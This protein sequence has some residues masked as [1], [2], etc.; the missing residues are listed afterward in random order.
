[1]QSL[2]ERKS[3]SNFLSRASSQA[4]DSHK[5]FDKRLSF[6]SDHKWKTCH[7]LQRT[8]GMYFVIKYYWIGL[9]NNQKHKLRYMD[10]EARLSIAWSDIEGLKQRVTEDDEY[11]HDR[12]PK[13]LEY[14][15]KY[16]EATE[17]GKDFDDVELSSTTYE[18]YKKELNFMYNEIYMKNSDYRKNVNNQI[19]ELVDKIENIIYDFNDLIWISN[20]PVNELTTKFLMLRNKTVDMKNYFKLTKDLPSSQNSDEEKR[21]TMKRLATLVQKRFRGYQVRKKMTGLTDVSFTDISKLDTQ[22]KDNMH[23]IDDSN[24]FKKDDN[25]FL[26][27]YILDYHPDKNHEQI[28]YVGHH[29]YYLLDVPRTRDIYNIICELQTVKEFIKVSIDTNDQLPFKLLLLM[30]NM[31]IL[32]GEYVWNTGVIQRELYDDDDFY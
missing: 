27:H 13:L 11:Y 16:K 1:M 17:T 22:S 29:Q 28:K 26:K 25:E 5:F 32:I 10:L 7:E 19:T 8:F 4:A 18:D 9:T 30:F 31:F 14:K 21:R 3:S 23:I 20:S 2:G 24:Q 6:K 12:I 15:K